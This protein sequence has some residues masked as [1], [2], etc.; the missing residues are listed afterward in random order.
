MSKRDAPSIPH[1]RL[2]LASHQ[3]VLEALK[4][5]VDVVWGQTKRK[6][7][8]VTFNDLRRLGVIPHDFDLD[9]HDRS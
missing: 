7:R 3:T 5:A 6:D 2:S 4:L 9:A 1:P 8:V